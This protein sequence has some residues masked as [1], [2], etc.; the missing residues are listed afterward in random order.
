MV[1]QLIKIF[2]GSFGGPVLYENPNYLCPNTVRR[3][4]K[5]AKANKYTDKIN[6]KTDLA[7]RRQQETETYRFDKTEEEV[8]DTNAADVDGDS[9]K[10]LN[11]LK[12]QIERKKRK[13]GAKKMKTA[14]K[15]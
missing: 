6:A 9:K 3:E 10:E 13:K 1:L 11:Q 15:S 12:R 14:K 4:Q 8:F 2:E 7:E 5:F